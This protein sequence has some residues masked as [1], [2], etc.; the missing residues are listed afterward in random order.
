MAADVSLCVSHVIAGANER[1]LHSQA[2]L[3]VDNEIVFILVYMTPDPITS[4]ACLFHF[5]RLLDPD[6]YKPL[7]NTKKLRETC[8]STFLS[9]N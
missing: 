7:K 8:D 5:E 2:T 9:R 3:T 4:E 6:D 1:W